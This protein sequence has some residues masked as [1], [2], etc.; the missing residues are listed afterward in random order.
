MDT[1]LERV[2]ADVRIG[3][4]D[5]NA[6]GVGLDGADGRRRWRRRRRRRGA[7]RR[8]RRRRRR[9]GGTGR[10]VG[11]GALALVAQQ[12][13]FDGLQ[14]PQSVGRLAPAEEF[15]EFQLVGHFLV[16]RQQV[17]GLLAPT[18]PE[19]APS[20]KQSIDELP[21]IALTNSKSKRTRKSC[22]DQSTDRS[23]RNT[24]ST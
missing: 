5:V 13:L 17:E 18:P 24:S 20:N 22:L 16:R 21:A 9:R 7:V 15:A 4:R 3:E 19:T 10:R 8:R 1:N 12:R 23:L 6:D 14:Q 2:G 11:F